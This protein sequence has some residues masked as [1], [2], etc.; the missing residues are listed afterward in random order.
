MNEETKQE[1]RNT[2]HDDILEKRKKDQ[3]SC[4]CIIINFELKAIRII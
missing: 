4:N 3:Q 1:F 2:D